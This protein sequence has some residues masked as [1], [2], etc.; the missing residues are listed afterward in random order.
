MLSYIAY[1]KI[2]FLIKILLYKNMPRS[3]LNPD[4]VFVFVGSRGSAGAGRQRSA[5]FAV[6]AAASLDPPLT[7]GHCSTSADA[8]DS[9]CRKATHCA[10]RGRA[11]APSL[12]YGQFIHHP[13]PRARASILI[14]M[15]MFESNWFWF[16]AR[17]R[18]WSL[19]ERRVHASA[20]SGA[21]K[22]WINL[23]RFTG[24]LLNCSQL[25]HLF[26]RKILITVLENDSSN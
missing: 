11:K 26:D 23:I 3:F 18:V 17:A 24:T 6:W 20:G 8:W 13:R 7:R 14:S 25:L 9:P 21:G 16:C 10:S 19:L 5:S 1:C 15:D 4:W 12:T 2:K 22:V